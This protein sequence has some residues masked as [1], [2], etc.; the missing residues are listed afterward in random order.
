MTFDASNKVEFFLQDGEAIKI[1]GLPNRG[2]YSVTEENL[3][4]YIF[5]TSGNENGV[6]VGLSTPEVVFNN[7][8]SS[9]GTLEVEKEVTGNGGNRF[10]QFKFNLKVENLQ[11]GVYPAEIVNKDTGAKIS[12]NLSFTDE[13]ASFKLKHR[14]GISVNLPKDLTYLVT[15]EDYSPEGYTE[16]VI[17]SNSGQLI[18][19][20]KIEMKF[21]NDRQVSGETIVIPPTPSPQ[22]P[23]KPE[24]P[25]EP[26]EPE[27][28][29]EEDEIIEVEVPEIPQIVKPPENGSVEI[30]EDGNWKY[31]PNPGFTGKDTF[32]IIR[33][34]GSEEIIEIDVDTPLGG[35]ESPDES[36]EDK[37]SVEEDVEKLPKT[38]EV[39]NIYIYLLGFTL[40]GLGLLI[41]K[42]E[43]N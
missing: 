13:V 29:E 37:E 9:H 12:I 30:D 8:R 16:E 35:F 7:T 18:V 11:D 40:I 28:P 5:E 38:G 32:T 10:K 19:N 4:E 42:K 14:E 31:T 33:P 23:P 22:D 39:N 27:I 34:D 1:K 2:T 43:L 21:I 25:Q 20:D 24:D 36:P 3:E 17:G 41:K 15:E 26:Q 6:I